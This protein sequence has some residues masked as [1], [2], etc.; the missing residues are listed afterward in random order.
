MANSPGVDSAITSWLIHLMRTDKALIRVR[1]ARLLAS[2]ARAEYISRAKSHTIALLV[3]PLLLELMKSSDPISMSQVVDPL[4]NPLS[5]ALSEVPRALGF[6]LEE[7]P[8]TSPAILKGAL[9][10]GIAKEL[11][12]Y[13]KKTFEAIENR[14]PLWSENADTRVMDGDESPTRILGERGLSAKVVYLFRCRRAGLSLLSSIAG[15]RPGEDKYRKALVENGVISCLVDSLTPFNAG[16][17]AAL[18]S[19]GG[20]EKLDGS[21]G[22]PLPVLLAACEASTAMARS[23][24]L[25]RTS[26]IDAGLAKPVCRL[27]QHPNADVQVA[28]L[29]VMCNMLVDCSPMRQVSSCPCVFRPPKYV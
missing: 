4:H 13:L 5:Q 23:I 10:A 15:N 8:I 20:K 24:Y 25:L 26:L 2:I 27:V 19:Q 17:V 1:A 7:S 16:S 12:Q 28:A 11:C 22:N 6:L 18:Q 14:A 21:I 9:E 29:A 3:I